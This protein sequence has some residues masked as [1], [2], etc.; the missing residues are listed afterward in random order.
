MKYLSFPWAVVVLLAS[1]ASAPDTSPEFKMPP[2]KPEV[3][4]HYLGHSS[5]LFTFDN[6]VTL[7]T[8]PGQS[9]AYGLDSPVYELGDF[10]PSIVTFSHHHPDHDRGQSFPGATVLDGKGV[11]MKGITIEA[12]PVSEKSEGD[13]F[14][15]LITYKGVTVFHAGDSQGDMAAL[16][17]GQV[18]QSL[19]AKLPR[20]LDVL[21]VPI[22]FIRP[23][24]REAAAYVEF[25]QPRTVIPM[26]FWSA[27]E[28]TG[29]LEELKSRGGKFQI[30][31]QGSSN[32]A[33][34]VSQTSSSIQVIS[35]TAGPLKP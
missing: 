4:I 13:N 3:Q 5:F 31:D 16:S 7:L 1:C 34:S 30:I 24:T 25:L 21:L 23:I 10:K 32:W 20:R 28:K 18:K 8:D 9:R 35:L 27:A 19:K 2:A 6:G 14:G 29:F 15:F 33:V 12:I 11:T 26:H 17:A 22:G